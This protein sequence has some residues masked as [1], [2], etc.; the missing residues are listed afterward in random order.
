MAFYVVS[1]S[2]DRSFSNSLFASTFMSFLSWKR[3]TVTRIRLSKYYCHFTN[4]HHCCGGVSNIRPI[5]YFLSLCITIYTQCSCSSDVISLSMHRTQFAFFC[6]FHFFFLFFFCGWKKTNTKSFMFARFNS[7]LTQPVLFVI[8]V[9]HLCAWVINF[10]YPKRNNIPKGFN[11][12]FSCFL[13]WTI[14]KRHWWRTM[15]W[16]THVNM[17]K[18]AKKWRNDSALGT[19]KVWMGNKKK[20]IIKICSYVC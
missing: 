19:S 18:W 15:F 14:N 13:S 7:R 5:P 20:N 12:H 1:F 4:D 17:D 3:W 8:L 11:I 16:S 9:S 6:F 2:V 10:C